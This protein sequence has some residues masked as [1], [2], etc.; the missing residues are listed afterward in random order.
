MN[1]ALWISQGILAFAFGAAGTMKL[2][3]YEKYRAMLE[4]TTPTTLTH[5]QLTLLGLAEVAGAIGVIVPMAVNVAPSLRVGCG[6][7]G[8][9]YAVGHHLPRPSP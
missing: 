9:H 5:G 7:A 8:A 1:L 6:W 4:K 2:F 3:A